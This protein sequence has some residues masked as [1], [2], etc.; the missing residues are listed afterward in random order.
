MLCC[1][2]Q[3]LQTIIIIFQCK[4]GCF[5]MCIKKDDFASFG[6]KKSIEVSPARLY[7]AKA[8][9]ITCENSNILKLIDSNKLKPLM[10]KKYTDNAVDNTFNQKVDEKSLE[11]YLTP[12][13][14]D[15]ERCNLDGENDCIVGEYTLTVSRFKKSN[16]LNV[17]VTIPNAFMS[18]KEEFGT[19]NFKE[20]F[21]PIVMN[22]VN[23]RAFSRFWRHVVFEGGNSNII[24]LFVRKYTYNKEKN[25]YAFETIAEFF[26]T[27]YGNGGD[28]NE[29][30]NQGGDFFKYHD[31]RV[32]A[33]T[34]DIVDV[35][36]G[37]CEAN[38]ATYQIITIL[39]N[40]RG[41]EFHP[42][43]LFVNDTVLK[44]SDKP[45]K[46]YYKFDNGGVGLTS[47]SI[48]CALKTIDIWY[49]DF[50][51]KDED[52]FANAVRAYGQNVN[53]RIANRYDKKDSTIDSN[54]NE[55]EFNTDFYSL[56]K[57]IIIGTRPL[58]DFGKHANFFFAML[59]FGGLFS[60]GKT[61]KNANK[62]K[63]KKSK[64]KNNAVDDTNT[65]KQG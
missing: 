10:A 14:V 17:P 19:E 65:E 40:G 27:D 22:V 8:E 28:N 9:D 5:I 12:R 24:K 3:N 6:L 37:N 4:K 51:T 46:T 35:F 26:A 43:Q 45:P 23:A 29:K 58:S 20:I 60:L 30:I 47:V 41:A 31:K 38:M 61:E 44:G 42:S 64:K 2:K 56:M 52:F 13:P 62:E 57:E 53:R 7:Q 63:E 55:F 15:T 1:G 32:D 25:F 39:Q 50:S 18:R 11:A 36:C 49:T 16:F 34:Q 54:G 21:H 33:I 59:V 48:G